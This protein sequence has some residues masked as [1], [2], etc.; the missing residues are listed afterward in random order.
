MVCIKKLLIHDYMGNAEH[1]SRV[2]ARA[3]DYDLIRA[4]ACC[5][6]F[7]RDGNNFCPLEPCLC[8]PV[9]VRH[10]CCDPVHAYENYHL[11]MLNAVKV[12]FISLHSQYHWMARRKISMPCV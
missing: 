11:G 3:D 9:A 8:K 5:R 6:V 7:Y 4:A 12:E 10:L 2:S 1:K